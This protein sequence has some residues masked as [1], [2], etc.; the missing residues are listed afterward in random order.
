M[1][2]ARHPGQRRCH[3]SEIDPDPACPDDHEK[4]CKGD[5]LSLRT[6]SGK[7]DQDSI[8][9]KTNFMKALTLIELGSL[10]ETYRALVG[11]QL[12]EVIPNDR[13]LALG[14]YKDKITYLVVDLSNQ[15]PGLFLFDQ[16]EFWKKSAKP[17]PV[18][19][20]LNSHA[21]NLIFQG[22]SLKEGQGRV[23]DITLAN[24]ERKC[25]LECVLI[26]KQ[27]NLIVRTINEK[28][29]PKSIAWIKPREIPPPPTILDNAPPRSFVEIHQEWLNLF[30]QKSGPNQGAIGRES[31]SLDPVAQWQKIKETSIRKKNK[32]VAEIEK[33]YLA[34]TDQKWQELGELLKVNSL[35]EL[36]SDWVDWIDIRLS[37]KE[38]RE[39]AFFK[40]KQIRQKKEGQRLRMEVLRSE[41][42]KLE[43]SE[44]VPPGVAGRSGQAGLVDLFKKTESSGRKKRLPSGI[45]VY[46]GKTAK[47]NLRILRAARAWDFWLHLRDYPGAHAIIHRNKDQNIS[48]EELREVARWLAEE[49]LSRKAL[50]LGQ[51]LNVAVVQ[52]RFVKPI[53]GDHHGRVHYHGERNLVI[54][55]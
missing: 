5:L 2:L 22:I 16:L 26:P 52:C 45:E 12:Q 29:Q 27:S 17:K 46:I 50:A 3:H 13:G 9:L 6:S 8:V 32:A 33:D 20:F 36:W 1:E 55:W 4:F 18:S 38:N 44:Y 21:K 19:L 11:A 28:N 37:L 47:D 48:E 30:T 14:F 34:Q 35:A 15:S 23:V 39:R 54:K 10:C 7:I 24:K 42:A 51:K 41:I 53:K 25:E 40:A 31:S 43:K 49:S